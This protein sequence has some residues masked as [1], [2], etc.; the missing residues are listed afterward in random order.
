[1]KVTLN[2]RLTDNVGWLSRLLSRSP[3]Y[4]SWTLTLF[5][6]FKD[7]ESVM[8]AID[9]FDPGREVAGGSGKIP[10]AFLPGDFL[11]P[12]TV[13]AWG[14]SADNIIVHT[15]EDISLTFEV[16]SWQLSSVLINCLLGRTMYRAWFPTTI[17]FK[18]SK[19]VAEAK[20][21]SCLCETCHSSVIEKCIRS[22]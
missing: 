7:G 16:G 9:R 12:C 8:L 13:S 20:L 17:N 10:T 5:I 15:A 21:F 1:M 22:Y 19:V 3:T 14:P 11:I 18:H 2:I 6:Y 4:C